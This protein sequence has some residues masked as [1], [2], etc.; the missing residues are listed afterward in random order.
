[1]FANTI[2]LVEPVVYVLKTETC[3]KLNG[4]D[5]LVNETKYCTVNNVVYVKHATAAKSLHL[6]K[7]PAPL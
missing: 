3:Y 4:K 1:M 7:K 2:F 6:S 5:V